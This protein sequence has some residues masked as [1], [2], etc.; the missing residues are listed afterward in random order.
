MGLY[1]GGNILG[2]IFAF[3]VGHILKG[4]ILGVGGS[5]YCMI[6]FLINVHMSLLA[7]KIK[8]L[9]IMRRQQDTFKDTFQTA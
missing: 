7:S 5:A 2:R 4:L 6:C 3:E 9:K 1:L 8:H